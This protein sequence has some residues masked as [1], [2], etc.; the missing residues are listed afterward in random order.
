MG[1]IAWMYPAPHAVV[2]LT[3]LRRVP[4]ASDLAVSMLLASPLRSARPI[5]VILARD[6]WCSVDR[7]RS[8][9]TLSPLCCG[10]SCVLVR[11]RRLE[12][13]VS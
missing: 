12:L 5:A 11:D 13:I 2:I 6:G 8:I 1:V 9:A 7:L 3:R 10:L 4:V